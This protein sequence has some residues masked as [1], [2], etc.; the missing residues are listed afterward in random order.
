[1]KLNNIRAVT[2]VRKAV[3]ILINAARWQ[4]NKCFQILIT[5]SSMP[6]RCATRCH[7]GNYAAPIW[8]PHQ[9]QSTATGPWLC[10]KWQTKQVKMAI[11]QFIPW[12][13]D[14][15]SEIKLLK[16]IHMPILN[17][18]FWPK[19]YKWSFCWSY[20]FYRRT[21][22]ILLQLFP[23]LSMAPKASL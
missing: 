10:E 23:S 19:L 21:L 3:K 2:Y 6:E 18:M 13:A 14:T 9:I 17:P 4:F 15:N 12:Q 8:I 7:M 5:C 22:Y 20:N 16:S 11:K 1:M